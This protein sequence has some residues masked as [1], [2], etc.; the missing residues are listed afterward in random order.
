VFAD[1]LPRKHRRTVRRRLREI[2][3]AAGDAR[4]WDVFLVG[5]Q[6]TPSLATAEG[7]PALDYLTGYAMGERS[8]AQEQ[9][10]CIAAEA[11][12]SFM[13][14]SA[15]L[16]ALVQAPDG[17]HVPANF[18]ELATAQ[19]GTLLAAFNEAASANPSDPATLHR[20]RIGGKRLRYALEIFAGCF[21]PGFKD[22]LY[23]AVE[24]LQ[25]I[26]GS[27]QDSAVGTEHLL[28]LRQR[29]E[30]ALPRDWP[31]LRKGFDALLKALRANVPAGRRAFQKWRKNWEKLIR[32]FKVEAAVA[33][34]TV[35]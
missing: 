12:P 29:I 19:F 18:G 17:K 8:A 13:E 26:L 21:P 6:Q 4:D 22:T 33:T 27:I 11:G 34:V 24:Q 25:E 10:D 35:P 31:R 20:L 32:D 23:P 9:L 7:R 30:K 28:G 5:L 3:R 2:R 1:C 16:P 15:A 14:E